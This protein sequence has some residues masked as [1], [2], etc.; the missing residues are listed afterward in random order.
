[1]SR[2]KSNRES[3]A[4]Q[5]STWYLCIEKAKSEIIACQK[6]L[7]ALR[8]SI[9]FFEIQANSGISFPLP[10]DRHKKLS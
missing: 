8:K 1:M 6:R 4:K 2:D 10:K 7:Y 5:D 3:K 9:Q